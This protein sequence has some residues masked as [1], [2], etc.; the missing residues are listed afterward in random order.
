MV[1]S[2][3]YV[4]LSNRRGAQQQYPLHKLHILL[5][6][7]GCHSMLRC[8]YERVY[9]YENNPIHSRMGYG[10]QRINFMF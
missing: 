5:D 7:A 6:S 9:G 10:Q 2:R 8:F 3:M 4:A 1:Q